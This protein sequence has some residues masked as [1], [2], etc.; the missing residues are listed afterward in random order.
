MG[1]KK[2]TAFEKVEHQLSRSESFIILDITDDGPEPPYGD[3]HFAPQMIIMLHGEVIVEQA[4]R[5]IVCH[6]GDVCLTAPYLPHSVSLGAGRSHYLVVTFNFFAL[7]DF[8]P[9]DDVNY[10]QLFVQPELPP[11]T[12]HNRAEIIHLARKISTLGKLRPANY[13]TG[14]FLYLQQILWLLTSRID[15]APAV[16]S[17]KNIMQIYPALLLA[18]SCNDKLISLDEA[19]DSCNL[20]RSRFSAVFKKYM[21]ISFN[22]FAMR[23][24]LS[25]IA[26]KLLHG[27][28]NSMKEIALESGFADVSHFY[29]TFRQIF[30]CTPLEF[31]GLKKPEQQH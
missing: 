11:P 26:L 6:G 29:R 12:R 8:S 2:N 22:A 3:V 10:L 14:Q 15:T 23:G 4:N 21:G 28:G 7:N 25:A 30:N 16:N 18:Q 9:F 5:E 20:S 31:I 1:R 13:R 19:A 24:R 17:R 27:E